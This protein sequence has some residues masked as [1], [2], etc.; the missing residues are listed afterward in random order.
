VDFVYYDGM[1]R[2]DANPKPLISR[3]ILMGFNVQLITV[4][5]KSPETIH[6]DLGVRPTG[7]RE[8]IPE[9]PLTGTM[10]PNGKYA[11][12]LNVRTTGTLSEREL[13]KLSENASLLSCDLSETTMNVALVAWENG[14]ETWSVWHDGGYQGVEHLE[15]YGDVPSRIE[16]IRERRFQEQQEKGDADYVFEIP[17]E[18]FV[19][20]GGFRYDRDLDV[21]DP[22]PWEVLERTGKTKKWW[23]VFG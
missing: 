22:E 14:T 21:D 2:I 15:L 11:L 17:V 1:A 5:G 19:E 16:P 4:D 23:Q 18:L 3:R 20:L 9:S 7:V 8:E 13:S 10:L 6:A 12:W